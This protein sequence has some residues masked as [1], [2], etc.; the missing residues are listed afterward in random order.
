MYSRNYGLRKKSLGKC[1]KNPIWEQPSTVNKASQTLLIIMTVSLSYFFK[2]LG[3]IE[4]EN[5]SVK[6]DD[7]HSLC[8]FG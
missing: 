2:T 3:K 7:L 1:F 8:L 4:L 6:K 5:V